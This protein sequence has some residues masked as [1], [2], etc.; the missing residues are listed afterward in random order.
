MTDKESQRMSDPDNSQ[1]R[2]LLKRSS[3]AEVVNVVPKRKAVDQ[4]KAV[5]GTSGVSSYNEEELPESESLQWRF[6]AAAW[7]WFR[8]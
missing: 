5:R 3:S 6:R 8:K 1:E 4:P 7:D 2:S